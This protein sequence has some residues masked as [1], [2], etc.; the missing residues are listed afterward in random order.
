M[1]SFFS[2]IR[3]NDQ[4]ELKGHVEFVE[5]GKQVVIGWICAIVLSYVNWFVLCCFMCCVVL[6]AMLLVIMC[7]D[8]FC[9]VASNSCFVMILYQLCIQLN[10]C[11]GI[12][13]YFT[14]H[15]VHFLPRIEI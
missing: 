6:C 5:P 8:V 9:Q 3:M 15:V 14:F 11:N 13:W 7:P 1:L 10:I 12:R 2:Q 4:K